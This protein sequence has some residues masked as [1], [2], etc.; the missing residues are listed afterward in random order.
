MLILLEAVWWICGIIGALWIGER[1]A[2]GGGR[3][4][5]CTRGRQIYNI[6]VS[7]L[8]LS[9]QRYCEDLG[10]TLCPPDWAGITDV[11]QRVAVGSSFALAKGNVKGNDI[12]G[13]PSQLT[14]PASRWSC[15]AL[16]TRCDTPQRERTTTR[17]L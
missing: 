15:D 1:H 5:A 10:K 11:T 12:L 6:S 4:E 3:Y 7:T 13:T 14:I 8:L 16:G 2:F 9:H 17:Q